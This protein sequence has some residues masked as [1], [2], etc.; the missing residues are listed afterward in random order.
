MSLERKKRIQATGV[1]NLSIVGVND[2]MIEWLN[3][4]DFDIPAMAKG[5]GIDHNHKVKATLSI[6]LVEEPCTICGKPINGD[7]ICQNCG[8]P[9]CDACAE[10]ENLERYCPIC[11][12]IKQ[13]TPSN[14]Q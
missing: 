13:P 6:E 2:H 11:K 8:K 7:K 9:I 12:V 10:T 4:L 14:T 5:I 3:A 1:L